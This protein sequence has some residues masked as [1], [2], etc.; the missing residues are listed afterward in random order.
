L[1]EALKRARNGVSDAAAAFARRSPAA[2]R[3]FVRATRLL[4]RTPGGYGLARRAMQTLSIEM[5]ARNDR[6]R[7]LH[8]GPV[9]FAIDVTDDVL[10]E[11]YLAGLPCEPLTTGW[12]LGALQRNAIF[13]DVGANVGYYTLLAARLVG[14]AGRV[15]AFEPNPAVR[16]RLEAHVRLNQAE[17]VVQIQP[18]ALA[19][20]DAGEIELFVPPAV[21]ESGIASLELSPA[22]AARGAAAVRVAGQRFDEWLDHTPLARIDVMKIDVEGAETAV[23]GGMRRV[24]AAAPP[25]HIVCETSWGGPAHAL[26]GDAG[27]RAQPLDWFDRAAGLANVLYSR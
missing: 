13:V 2:E 22:L 8:V 10:R 26:L 5:R 25:S 11:M 6:V 15:V 19:D 3:L 1:T 24:L 27:Y 12:L 14:P 16:A 7:P 9:H 18:F 4:V 17:A 21:A 23:L 20:S